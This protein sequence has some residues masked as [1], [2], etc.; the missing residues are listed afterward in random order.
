LRKIRDLI[1]FR[2]NQAQMRNDPPDQ[3]KAPKFQYKPR[4]C[5]HCRRRFRLAV[6]LAKSGT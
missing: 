3:A 4:V 2:A 1:I 6:A 5:W